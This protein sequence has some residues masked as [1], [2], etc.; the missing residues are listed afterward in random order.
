MGA[1]RT[2]EEGGATGDDHVAQQ[3]GPEL[4]VRGHG[5]GEHALVHAGVLHAHQRRVK[6]HL[7]GAVPLLVHLRQR[8]G[9]EAVAGPACRCCA[10]ARPRRAVV[11]P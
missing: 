2:G 8:G 1:S 7:G 11:A 5:G 10:A 9:E 4:H 3:L 6:Q